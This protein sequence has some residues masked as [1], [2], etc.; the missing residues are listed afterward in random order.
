[1][2]RAPILKIKIADE[3]AGVLV[4]E[5]GVEA[6]RRG[7]RVSERKSGLSFTQLPAGQRRHRMK[8]VD[9]VSADELESI[10]ETSLKVLEE[11][12]MDFIHEGAKDILREKGAEVAK[13]SD[14]SFPRELIQQSIATIPEQFELV[15]RNPARNRRSRTGKDCFVMAPVASAPRTPTAGQ[16]TARWQHARFPELPALAQTTNVADL[17]Q[18]TPG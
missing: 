10:H 3:A 2:L 9:I 11:I 15:T 17:T 6:G 7:A 4:G 1:M 5:V 12:G 18:G 8:P 16:G 14:R 13:D